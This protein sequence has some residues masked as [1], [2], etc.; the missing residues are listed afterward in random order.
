MYEQELV[1]PMLHHLR[2]EHRRLNKDLCKLERAFATWVTHESQQMRSKTLV[3][4]STVEQELLRHFTEEEE[5]GCMEEAVSRCPQLAD[6]ALR[7][8]AEHEDILRRF[9]TL[10]RQFES[11]TK[12]MRNTAELDA[13]FKDLCRQV[14]RHEAEEERIL[15]HAFG[16]CVENEG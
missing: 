6:A 10:I 5:G 1:Y 4:L 9:G 16:R 11:S 8:E 15:T 13:E 12:V 7:L 14:H 2:A 3:G